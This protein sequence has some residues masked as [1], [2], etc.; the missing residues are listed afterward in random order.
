[1]S[2]VLRVSGP[3]ID[4][5]ECLRWLPRARVERGRRLRSIAVPPSFLAMLSES[6]VGLVVSA[7]P[8]D[9]DDG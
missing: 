3:R 7:Y 1:M 4:I 8:V 9:D 6:G 2:A 5:D